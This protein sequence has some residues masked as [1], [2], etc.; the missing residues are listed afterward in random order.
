MLSQENY[1]LKVTVKIT[2]GWLVTTTPK[3]NINKIS[4][5]TICQ[6]IAI[7]MKYF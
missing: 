2:F 1:I 7:P 6:L 4:T 3:K 5:G